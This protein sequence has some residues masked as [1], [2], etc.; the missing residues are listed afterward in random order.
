MAFIDQLSDQILK[1]VYMCRVIDIYYYF[2]FCILILIILSDM[3]KDEV[4]YSFVDGE[5]QCLQQF[6]LQL[7]NG[8]FAVHDL[9]AGFLGVVAVGEFLFS[10]SPAAFEMYQT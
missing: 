5:R 1:E 6:C 3:R 9:G 2:H 8:A 10:S 7:I 4:A